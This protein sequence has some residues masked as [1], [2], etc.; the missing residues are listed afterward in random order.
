[1]RL[2]K[3]KLG[4]W[5]AAL[6]AFVMEIVDML[7]L[8]LMATPFNDALKLVNVIAMPMVPGDTIGI[9]IFVLMLHNAP[10]CHREFR[11]NRNVAISVIPLPF[12]VSEIAS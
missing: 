9:A 3:G 4:I 5:K 1:L 7:L 6:Y 2:F 8:L 10:P 12:C 11:C